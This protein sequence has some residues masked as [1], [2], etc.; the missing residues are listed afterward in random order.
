MRK[1]PAANLRLGRQSRRWLTPRTALATALRTVSSVSMID[2]L[3][4]NLEKDQGLRS[5]SFWA[6][7]SARLRGAY[8]P[9]CWNLKEAAT[10][11]FATS[12]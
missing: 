1:Q 7:T 6:L 11:V 3:Y 5:V 4:L 2:G 12:R 9:P 8:S 10:I